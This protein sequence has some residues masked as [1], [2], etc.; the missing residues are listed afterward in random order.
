M[1]FERAAR[2][3]EQIGGISI[4]DSTVWRLCQERSG[5]GALESS[6]LHS[7]WQLTQYERR[8]AYTDLLRYAS[9]V[10]AA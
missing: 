1:D 2:I 4:S 8:H 5:A 7:G 10:R 9:P 3:L 6:R